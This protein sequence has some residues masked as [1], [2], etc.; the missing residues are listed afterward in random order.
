MKDNREI[1]F[2]AMGIAASGAIHQMDFI[3]NENLEIFD[4]ALVASS[5]FER[6]KDTKTYFTKYAKSNSF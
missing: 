1:E 6:I 4:G 5:K 3:F 2:W